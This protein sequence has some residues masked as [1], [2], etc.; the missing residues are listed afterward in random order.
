MKTQSN[1]STFIFTV[2]A[3][4]VA[5]LVIGYFLFSSPDGNSEQ[6]PSEPTAI[7]TWSCSMHPQVQLQQAG[8]CPICGMALIPLSEMPVASAGD[9]LQLSEEAR[10]LAGIQTTEATQGI[11]EKEIRLFG[12]VTYDETRL[13]TI[14]AR[15]PARIEKLYVN[16][17]G[18]PVKEGDHLGS[19]YSKELLAAQ[20]DLITAL[21]FS[22]RQDATQGPKEQLR[23]WGFSDIHIQKIEESLE[24]QEF[25]DI[26]AP[27]GGTVVG[28]SI[29]E[30]DHVMLGDNLFT[31]A[32]L[33]HVWITFDA[34]ESDLPWIH[35]GQEITI[36]PEA[37]PGKQIVGK[38]SLIYPEIDPMSRT[39]KI[40][41]SIPNPDQLL[42]PGQFVRGILRAQLDES[43]TVVVPNLEGKWV[44]PMHPEIVK[45]GPGNCD[46]C[47]ME[48]VPASEMGLGPKPGY[49][50]PLLVPSS[51]VL[52]TGKRAVVYVETQ[53]AQ[54]PSYEGREVELG[55]RAG[56][57]FVILSGL[58]PGERVV[59]QGAF[60][61]DSALQI[62]A[63]PS[64][65]SK[66]GQ[67]TMN[68][69]QRDL[70]TAER[71]VELMPA[72]LALQKAL[73]GDNLED[74]KVALNQ[75]M[76]VTGH[77]G[78]IA[79]LIHVMIAAE[80]LD[81]IRKPHFDKLSSAI[82]NAVQSDPHAFD[83]DL[84]LMHCPMVYGATGADWIQDSDELRNPYFGAMMLTCG[85]VLENL[86]DHQDHNH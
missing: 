62:K 55:V 27:I 29:Q 63:K 13:R 65:M 40:R 71:G 58:E 24:A 45:D 43:G 34:Y 75:M 82:I 54:G 4:I 22:N 39:A 48:L 64:M 83:G 38:V 85:S 8:D 3:G 76:N 67:E 77:N 80:T 60:K 81:D 17:T 84:F 72:Y 78:P 35:Y 86:T 36:N 15:F 44:S 46:V 70:L 1:K 31:I 14:S 26:D 2:P 56:D 79:D 20:T 33:T 74:S 25:L 11:A 47:G 59:T 57:Q 61:I 37:N 21:K 49:G 30:G 73:A 6:P 28:K 68:E 23:Q 7:E 12:Q 16:A 51:S 66:T 41:V 69:E 42:K 5:G 19:V 50:E 10:A 9:D 18:I 53:T 52:Q 32:D